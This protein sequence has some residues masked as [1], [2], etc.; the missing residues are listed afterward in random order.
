MIIIKKNQVKK[1]LL[2]VEFLSFD[3]IHI[4]CEKYFL[5]R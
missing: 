3:A 2:Y 5:H 4:M 1:I